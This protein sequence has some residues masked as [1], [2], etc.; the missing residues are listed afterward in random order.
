MG[1]ISKTIRYEGIYFVDEGTGE[2]VYHHPV[3]K[4]KVS[5]FDR[6]VGVDTKYPEQCV[7][8]ESLLDSLSVMDAYLD[9]QTTINF[10]SIL[11]STHIKGGMT[12]QESKLV[13]HLC[14][15]ICGWNYY[16]GNLA[17]LISCDV[18]SKNI[19]SVLSSLE[20]KYAIKILHRNKPLRGDIVLKVNPVYAWKGDVEYRSSR[21]LTWYGVSDT[22]NS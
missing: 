7:T 9:L 20:S 18:S 22:T 14:T 13:N 21:I 3:A 12:T 2:I 10:E 4:K 1:I 17:D 8:K 11:K 19:S 15:N 5:N 16:I 6:E